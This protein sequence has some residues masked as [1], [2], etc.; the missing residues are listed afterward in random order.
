MS[1]AIALMAKLPCP[2]AVKTRLAAVIGPLEAAA[3][4]LAF[5]Q[6]SAARV[7]RLAAAFE[8]EPVA[9]HAPPGAGAAMAARLPPG[10]LCL[11]QSGGDV[12]ERM[13]RG[14]DA[15]FARGHGPVLLTGSDVPTLPE[16]LLRE[17]LEAVRGGSDAALVPVRDGGYCAVALAKPAP[18]LFAGVAW[19]T[20]SVMAETASAASRAGLRLHVTAPWYD[21]DEYADLETL[22]AE[23]A[24]RAPPGCAPVPGDPAPATRAMLLSRGAQ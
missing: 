9:L 13:A 10:F 17:A 22:R 16:A 18:V 14:S 21:V 15:L 19:S 24:G 23:F 12:G 3:L 6:D 20:A 11:A 7:A 8:A 1:V 5:L 2:G 4:A